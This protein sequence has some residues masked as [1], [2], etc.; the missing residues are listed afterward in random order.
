M[1]MWF[2]VCIH[3]LGLLDQMNKLNGLKQQKCVLSH[4]WRPEV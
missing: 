2:G 4:F 3:F 1:A